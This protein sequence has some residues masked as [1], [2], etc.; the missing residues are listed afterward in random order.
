MMDSEQ[1]TKQRET[2]S[3]LEKISQNERNKRRKILITAAII[4][5]ALFCIRFLCGFASFIQEFGE[6]NR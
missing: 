2:L 3:E 4:I 6:I 5:T 1:N